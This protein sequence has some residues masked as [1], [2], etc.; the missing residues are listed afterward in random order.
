MVFGDESQKKQLDNVIRLNNVEPESSRNHLL[1]RAKQSVPKSEDNAVITV[2]FAA[3]RRMMGAMECRRYDVFRQGGFVIESQ[4]GMMKKDENQFDRFDRENQIGI[5]ANE[6]YEKAFVENLQKQ[7]EDV[8][9]EAGRDIDGL[10]A[11]MNLMKA[12]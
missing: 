6:D 1:A 12:P 7:I 3:Q 11:M 4:V 9:T 2:M 8:K 10:V 5:D